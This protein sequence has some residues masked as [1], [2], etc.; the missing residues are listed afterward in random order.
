MLTSHTLASSASSHAPAFS[1]DLKVGP[2]SFAY[3]EA[4]AQFLDD[5]ELVP[6]AV[7]LIGQ[8]EMDKPGISLKVEVRRDAGLEG[9]R[10]ILY[11]LLSTADLKDRLRWIRFRWTRSS[12]KNGGM[13]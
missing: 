1:V 2:G 5:I 3:L 10:A 13:V 12:M 4:E 7:S 6:D 11:L 9:C 8:S